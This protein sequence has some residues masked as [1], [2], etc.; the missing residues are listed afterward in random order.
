MHSAPLAP[1]AQFAPAKLP[2][3]PSVAAYRHAIDLVRKGHHAK[4]SPHFSYPFGLGSDGLGNVYV[5]NLSTSSVTVIGANLKATAGVIT[6]G[7]FQPVSVAADGLGNVYVGNLNSG[8]GTVTKYTN[9]Q[10]QSTFTANTATPYSI[11]LDAFDDLYVV[12]GAGIALDD[13]YGNQLYGPEY[14]GYGVISVATGNT[15]IYAFTNDADLTGNG[16]V[17]LRSGAM[18]GMV[19]PTAST[20]PL[21]VACAENACWYSD[22]VNGT[23]SMSMNGVVSSVALNY[24]P[25]GVAFDPTHDRLFVADP[26]NNAVHVYNPSTLAFEKTII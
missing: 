15:A 10:P 12:S 18:Q 16:S 4:K 26:A 11:A 3:S 14:N 5:T 9:G 25:V 7:L 6:Q 17:F 24:T 13:P 23:V 1:G 22:S 8:V 2:G 21:G 20:S 19:G